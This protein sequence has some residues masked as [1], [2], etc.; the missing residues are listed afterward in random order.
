MHL[1]SILHYTHLPHWRELNSCNK[2]CVITSIQILYLR[3]FGYHIENRCPCMSVLS[4]LWPQLSPRT[5][6]ALLQCG[7]LVVLASRPIIHQ[8][9]FEA[10]SEVSLF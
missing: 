4:N 6:R 2:D 5:V 1:K 7:F 9:S 8:V 3:I 10:D